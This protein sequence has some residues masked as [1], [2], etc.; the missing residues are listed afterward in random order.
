M[1]GTAARRSGALRARYPAG[2]ACLPAYAA[3]LAVC[4]LAGRAG[5]LERLA[6]QVGVLALVV[7]LVAFESTATAGLIAAGSALLSLNGFAENG[8]GVLAPHPA[9]DLP[10]AAVLL[11]A[12]ASGWSARNGL[13]TRADEEVR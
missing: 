12:A 8:L 1:H 3:P 7:A 11:L 9:V 13:A 4:S 5:S 10:A 2:L 6:A